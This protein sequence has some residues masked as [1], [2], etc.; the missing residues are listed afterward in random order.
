[1]TP[2]AGS[3]RME[4][5]MAAFC[6]AGAVVS[7]LRRYLH[8]HGWRRTAAEVAQR[9]I[10]REEQLIVLVKDLG[11]IVQPRAHGEIGLED[12][13]AAHLPQLAQLNRKR[14]RPDADRRF[15][16]DLEHGFHGFVGYR[17]GEL[18]GYYWWVDRD[19]RSLHRDLRKL[20]LGIELGEGEVYGS[21][22]FLLEEHRGGGL[23]GEFLFGVERRLRERGYSRLWGYVASDNR[24][25]RWVYS[26]RGYE[27]MWLVDRRRALIFRRTTHRSL[28]E[29]AS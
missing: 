3:G 29:A 11:A 14:G 13:G 19:A 21:D 4:I 15:A 24:P 9:T 17:D 5:D 10:G 22:F 25:A 27:P 1:M 16:R 2:R 26:T 23:A 7:R 18:A 20:G 8:A 28:A 6:H 12:L